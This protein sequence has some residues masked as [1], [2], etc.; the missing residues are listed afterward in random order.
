MLLELQRRLACWRDQ[1]P[2]RFPDS[3]WRDQMIA[4]ARQWS[5]RV[6]DMSGLLVE[7]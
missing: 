5:Q 7:A 2:Q 4:E 3:A 1:L 6:L